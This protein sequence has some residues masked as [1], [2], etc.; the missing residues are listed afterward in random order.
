VH[1]L[2]IL[3][4][5][6]RTLPPDVKLMVDV[7]GAYT[8]PMALEVGRELQRLGVYWYEE[9]LP[10]AGY[11]GYEALAAELDLPVAG[12]EMLQSRTAFKE[13]LDRRAVDIVQPDISICG[14]VGECMF[15]AELAR[16]HGVRCVP[17]TWNGA[18]MNIATLHV[19]A[20]LPEASRLAGVDAPLLEFDSTD[21]PFMRAELCDPPPLR[22]GCFEVPS[23]PGLG[24]E[25]DETWLRQHA[26]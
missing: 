9:P 8:P 10:Q 5:L 25:V 17:H 3:E 4:Q 22:D 21:N 18:I 24:V 19:A 26:T 7:W 23:G 12:G 16:L 13:L 1:E 15:V 6:R 2:R 20:A 11:I 14:G